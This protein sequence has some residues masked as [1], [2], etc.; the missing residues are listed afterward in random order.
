MILLFSG[1][2][3]E[4]KYAKAILPVRRKGNY[5]LCTI[6]IMNVIVNSAI[7]I[8]MGDLT[9]GL[10]AFIVASAGIVVFGEICPQA[11]CIK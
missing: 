11:V 3:R 6:L 8:L 9:S 4:R 7:S 1:S 10:I 2:E 5:L